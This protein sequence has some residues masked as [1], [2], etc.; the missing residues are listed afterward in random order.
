M[1]TLQSSVDG[2]ATVPGVGT[3]AFD[4]I[5]GGA[6][7]REAAKDRGPGEKFDQP[8]PGP[9]SV[10]NVTASVMWNEDTHRPLKSK[11]DNHSTD[12]VSVT[13]FVR[14]PDGN[15][16]G[17]DTWAPCVIVRVTGPEGNTN[18]GNEKARLEVEFAVGGIA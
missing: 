6:V 3:I 4:T 7:T 16:K 2:I 10:E 8:V 5:T 11:L 12:D 13:K 9:P 1:K 17:Q 18:S 15:R 14:D